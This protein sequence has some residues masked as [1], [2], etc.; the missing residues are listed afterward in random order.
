MSGFADIIGHEQVIEHLQ[1]A[2]R[3][4]RISHAYI[5][6]GPDGA[7][8]KML[9]EAFAQAL[10][11]EEGGNKP[12]GKCHSCVQAQ[13]HSHPDII[14]V[15]HEKPRTIRVDDIRQQINADMA[16]RPYSSPYKIYIV[17]EAEKM[18]EAA[19]NALLKTMEEPPEYGIILLLSTSSEVFLP[20]ITSRCVT[21]K[22]RAVPDDE[23]TAY[24][25]KKT[26]ISKEKADV[27][28][29][30]AQGVIGKALLLAQSEDFTQ[31]KEGAIQLIKRMNRID[32]HEMAQA[33]RQINEYHMELTDYL[34]ILAV[35]YR[36]VLR[37]K[38]TQDA[39]DLILKDEA[40]EI[41]RQANLFSYAGL[42]AIIQAI[43]QAK[44]RLRANVNYDLTM[45]LLFETIKEYQK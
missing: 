36:D 29:A 32:S 27:C 22:L 30:F 21:L 9:A 6:E 8:K 35:W 11:C 24:I 44:I 4:D 14:Y 42:E 2:I 28:A 13:S 25:I 15:T 19:Q 34:D 40:M 10:Q 7:G 45:E 1:S 3:M 37:F 26:G 16:I 39:N 23:V 43:Y 5:F 12:C 17:D 38:A 31:V 33:I 41:K 20:T 18:N